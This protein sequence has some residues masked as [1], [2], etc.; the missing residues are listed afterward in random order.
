MQRVTAVADA[1]GVIAVHALL[2]IMARLESI[3]CQECVKTNDVPYPSISRRLQQLLN[4]PFASTGCFQASAMEAKTVKRITLA[5]T[6]Q[7]WC[8]RSAAQVCN[9]NSSSPSVRRFVFSAKKEL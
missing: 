7:A 9:D 4:G 2:V 6:V 5:P 1:S 3:T 8:K